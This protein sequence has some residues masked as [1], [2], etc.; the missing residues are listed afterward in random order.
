MHLPLLHLHIAISLP[1][2][3]LPQTHRFYML[4]PASESVIFPL[5]SSQLP[6]TDAAAAVQTVQQQAVE[7]LLSEIWQGI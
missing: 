1:C 3:R 6:L 4:K 2:G 5:Q 7:P